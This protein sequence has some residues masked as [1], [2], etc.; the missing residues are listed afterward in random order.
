MG[1]VVNRGVFVDGIVN[2]AS[3]EVMQ[4]EY[5]LGTRYVRQ[6]GKRKD[7]CTIV[8]VLKTYNAAGDL[9][10]VRYVAT[11]DFLGQKVLDADVCA[12]TVARGLLTE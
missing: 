5:P 8:D 2:S 3:I 7:V 12:V 4:N 6:C 1:A 9:V 11:H 10:R